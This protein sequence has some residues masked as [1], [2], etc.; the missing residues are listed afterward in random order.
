[1][2]W[3]RSPTPF[4]RNLNQS[5]RNSSLSP[6]HREGAGKDL[7]SRRDAAGR[8]AV[9]VHQRRARLAIAGRLDRHLPA[10][11][12]ADR[13]VVT[14]PPAIEKPDVENEFQL[15]GGAHDDDVEHA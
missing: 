11:Q 9:Y 1:M 14:M 12:D 10:A 5:V 7:E 6:A 15:G 3:N 8:L 2:G 13:F 4:G